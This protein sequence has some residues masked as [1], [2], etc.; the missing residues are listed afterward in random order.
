MSTT[1]AATGITLR[2][3]TGGGGQKLLPTVFAAKVERLSIALGVDRSRFINR[4]AADGIFDFGFRIVH[5]Q[6]PLLMVIVT[7]KDHDVDAL[8]RLQTTHKRRK[9]LLLLV[10]QFQ[11]QHQVVE[12]HRVFQCE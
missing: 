7:I 2:L 5:S 4:H 8:A 3:S 9:A 6:V 11:L 1:A 10:V 12:L